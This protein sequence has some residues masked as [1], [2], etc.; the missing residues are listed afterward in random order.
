MFNKYYSKSRNNI[1]PREVVDTII[2]NI[3]FSKAIKLSQSSANS[4]YKKSPPSY[5]WDISSKNGDLESIKWLHKNNKQGFSYKNILEAS[6]NNHFDVV[7]YLALIS[8]PEDLYCALVYCTIGYGKMLVSQL[9]QTQ[10]QSILNYTVKKSINE[11]RIKFIFIMLERKDKDGEALYTAIITNNNAAVGVLSQ[12]CSLELLEQARLFAISK[13][14][15]E[16]I[17][18]ILINNI[19]RVHFLN[20]EHSKKIKNIIK[21]V[22]LEATL[23]ASTYGLGR[24]LLK[25]YIARKNRLFKSKTKLKKNKK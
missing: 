6:K 24:F 5:Y 10:K 17:I 18:Q 16:G 9:N 1:L 11:Q 12:Y 8:K 7:K 19:Q 14:V 21:N 4:I 25:S 2:E 20:E 15:N 22:A 13:N 23:V 3:P